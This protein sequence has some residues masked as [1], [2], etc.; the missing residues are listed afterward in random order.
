M[1]TIEKVQGGRYRTDSVDET[2]TT[3]DR[4]DV[5]E[6]QAAYLCDERRDFRR[7]DDDGDEAADPSGEAEGS[8]EDEFDADAWLEQ[9]FDDRA[10]RVRAGDVDDHL[11]EIADEETSDTVLDAIGERR[12][13][14]EA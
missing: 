3:G 12:A 2:V 5:D 13:E 4:I 7:V 1:V 14:L 11:E 10:D 6:A 9:D 8:D